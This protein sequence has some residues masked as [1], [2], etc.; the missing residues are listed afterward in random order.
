[1][2]R[3]ALLVAAVA[4]VAGCGSNGSALHSCAPPRGPG[5]TAVH[6]TDLRA[7]DLG[8]AGARKVALACA[9]WT[10][11]SSGTCTALGARWRCTSD[12]GEG[13]DSTQRCVAGHRTMRVTWTD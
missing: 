3:L 12:E 1:M 6:S 5:D 4:V 8:C 10:Y 7:H 13:A 2:I 11:G 9:R